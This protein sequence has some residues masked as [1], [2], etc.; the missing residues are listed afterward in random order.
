MVFED[1]LCIQRKA[2]LKT[3]LRHKWYVWEEGLKL[4]GIPLSRLLLH[5]M[6]KLSPREFEAYRKKFYPLTKDEQ[7]KN[8]VNFERAWRAHWSRNE[9]H[10]NFWTD[11]GK[12]EGVPANTI[13]VAP[14]PEEYVREMV[15]DWIAASK[16]YG[17]GDLQAWLA[18]AYGSMWFHDDT[19]EILRKVL[20]EIDVFLPDSSN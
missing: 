16:V 2:Y 12:P 10:W 4:G 13:S 1:L 5:D 20:V 6:S 18:K 9:H 19:L 17:D 8:E 7:E 14:M 3:I 11:L 15:A